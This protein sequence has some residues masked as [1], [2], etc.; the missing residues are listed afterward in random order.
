MRRGRDLELSA[1]K[2][3]Q[4]FMFGKNRIVREHID[5]YLKI[6]QETVSTFAAAMEHYREHGID[7]HFQIGRASC[8]ER[9]CHR[10]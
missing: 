1:N 3:K 4:M 6:M 2:V 8:R 5:K 7:E 9:G 10:V